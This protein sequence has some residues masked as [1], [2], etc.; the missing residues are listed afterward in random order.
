VSP[1]GEWNEKRDDA[2]L[3]RSSMPGEG[4]STRAK[5]RC[6]FSSRGTHPGPARACRT[7][8]ARGQGQHELEHGTKDKK[9]YE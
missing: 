7:A 5:R 9:K 8:T 2:V 1:N 3:E 4:L 6:L